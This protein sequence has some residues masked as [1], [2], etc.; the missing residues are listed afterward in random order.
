MENYKIL[1]M[2]GDEYKT[3]ES[4]KDFKKGLVTVGTSYKY[5]DLVV[6]RVMQQEAIS[7]FEWSRTDKGPAEWKAEAEERIGMLE[8]QIDANPNE[9]ALKSEKAFIEKYLNE[10]ARKSPE[11][12]NKMIFEERTDG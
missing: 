10:V 3:E 6:D 12:L 4:E 11:E 7:I 1:Y 2:G 9:V 5:G 8:L